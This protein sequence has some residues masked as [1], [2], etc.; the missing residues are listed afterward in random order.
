[1]VVEDDPDALEFLGL[2]LRQTGA[3]VMAFPHPAPAYEYY[4]STATP[5]D[6]IVSDIAMP[7][8]DGYSFLWRLRAWE[9]NQGRV[10]VPAIAVSAFGRAEDVQRARAHGFDAHLAKPVDACQL[11]E[12]IAAWALPGA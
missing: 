5:P 7:G 11:I 10:P 3:T 2:I 8:E 1:M 12:L 9:T 6:L 4:C